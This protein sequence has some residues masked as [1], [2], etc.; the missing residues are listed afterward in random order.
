[1]VLR[2]RVV[3]FPDRE[4]GETTAEW[5]LRVV[6][7]GLAVALRTVGGL[8]KERVA[9][10][11]GV[12]IGKFNDWELGLRTA[13]EG[14]LGTWGHLLRVA[15]E[16]DTV[17][18]PMRRERRLIGAVSDDDL[19]EPE[20]DADGADPPAR[21]DVWLTVSEVAKELRLTE[22][23]V[24]RALNRGEIGGV[25]IGRTW[26]IPMSEFTIRR[27]ELNLTV[28]GKTD[29][30]DQEGAPT[31]ITYLDDIAVENVRS[32][33]VEMLDTDAAYVMIYG[34]RGVDDFLQFEIRARGGKLRI[35]QP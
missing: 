5:M 20:Q 7:S 29:G 31:G 18:R 9:T 8:S 15:A 19:P 24:R 2:E 10:H 13:P 33:H 35:Y 14:A 16:F 27:R 1:M 12:P 25:L 28:T 6:Q 3:D 17:D 11:L 21:G 30:D 22:D 26:R 4:V 23:M 32:V 34:A